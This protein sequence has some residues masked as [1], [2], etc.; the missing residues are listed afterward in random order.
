[1]KKLISSLISLAICAAPVD[2]LAHPGHMQQEGLH[3]L[4]RTEHLVMLLA[5]IAVAG[6]LLLANRD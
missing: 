4:L 3:A 5:A 6:G 1:M 2:L